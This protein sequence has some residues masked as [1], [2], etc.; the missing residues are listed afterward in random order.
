MKDDLPLDDL[1][2]WKEVHSN[3]VF[4]VLYYMMDATH[5]SREDWTEEEIEF[6][7]NFVCIVVLKVWPTSIIPSKRIGNR[8]TG[9]LYTMDM[10]GFDTLLEGKDYATNLWENIEKEEGYEEMRND[11]NDSIKPNLRQHNPLR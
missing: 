2:N 4:S 9:M 3:P 10:K 5:Y 1:K 8:K 11:I 6:T 7:K